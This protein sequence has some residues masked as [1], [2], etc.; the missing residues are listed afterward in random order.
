[1]RLFAG[2]AAL[3]AAACASKRERHLLEAQAEG[4]H[5]PRP[6][7]AQLAWHEAG[8]GVVFHYD[9]HVFDGE[10]YSQGANRKAVPDDPDV[11]QPH[12]L[13]CDQWIAAAK[14]AGARFA[15]L[16]ASHETG[17]RLWQSD[18]NPFS[19]RATS[20]RGG[21]GDVVREFVDACRRADIAPGIYLGTRWNAQLGVLDHKVTERS[22]ITQARYAALC[23]AEVEEI[24]TRYGPLF[25]LWFDAGAGSITK[26]GPNV[27]PIV[28]RHQPDCIFYHSEERA[29]VR[30]GGSESGTVPYP[31]WSTVRWP[32]WVQHQAE[33]PNFAAIKHGDPNGAHWMPAMSDA[34]LRGA[35][36][37]HEWFWEPGDED[38]LHSRDRLATMVEHS[39]GRNSTLILGLTPDP[40]G[41]MPEGDVARLAEMGREVDARWG[42][43]LAEV[44]PVAGSAVAIPLPG[45]RTVDRV[46]LQEDIAHGERVRAWRVEAHT[47]EGRRELARGTCVGHARWARFEAT[48]A[49]ALGFV[50][51]D[52]V[53]TPI[54]KSFRAFAAS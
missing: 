9:L 52:A 31:C 10:L 30:W 22:P 42:S 43:P 33:E 24:C 19:M 37:R 21:K 12:E 15:I 32:A 38:A 2:G 36:G 35:N 20:W 17:F 13:D 45:G 40:R 3:G 16:T 34:P 26:G 7:R 8:L 53:A 5:L 54:V 50:V 27:I 29:D 11:F 44:G 51:E 49:T 41:R 18:A 46:I 23:E 25:E 39:V 28:A 1:M 14:A 47:S 48:H 4:A 6:T